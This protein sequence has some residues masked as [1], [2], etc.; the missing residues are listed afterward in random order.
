MEVKEVLKGL[1]ETMGHLKAVNDM[2]YQKIR[3]IRNLI[4]DGIG[5]QNDPLNH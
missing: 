3:T 1:T 5:G 4:Y 2:K